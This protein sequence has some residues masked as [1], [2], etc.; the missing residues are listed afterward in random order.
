MTVVVLTT[1]NVVTV[2]V[3]LVEVNGVK[4]TVVVVRLIW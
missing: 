3:N 4:L 1:L 2:T